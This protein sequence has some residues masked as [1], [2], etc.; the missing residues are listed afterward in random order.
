M[1]Y[2]VAYSIIQLEAAQVFSNAIATRATVWVAVTFVTDSFFRDHRDQSCQPLYREFWEL[3]F[4]CLY[5]DELYNIF[6]SIYCE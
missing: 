3:R 1:V 4:I 6:P 2:Y 5:I